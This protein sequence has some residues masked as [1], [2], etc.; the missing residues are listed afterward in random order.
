MTFEDGEDERLASKYSCLLQREHLLN[1]ND[2]KR[3]ET[4][5]TVTATQRNYDALEDAC[6]AT[7]SNSNRTGMA[8]TTIATTD[9]DIRVGRRGGV[10]D[11]D[12]D[13][14]QNTNTT[15]ATTTNRNIWRTME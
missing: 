6:R 8:I 9:S 12:D 1:H 3:G 10:L 2:Q 7:T 5:R 11:D 4:G 15:A 14:N 13:G